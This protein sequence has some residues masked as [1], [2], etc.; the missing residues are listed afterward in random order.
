[1]KRQDLFGD[2][3]MA[4]YLFKLGD[5]NKD[6]FLDKNE[7]YNFYR[8]FI[9]F[10]FDQAAQMTYKLIDMGDLDKNTKLDEIGKI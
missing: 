3:A 5:V 1:M 7:I 9:K 4:D 10:S 6:K 8:H 2:F